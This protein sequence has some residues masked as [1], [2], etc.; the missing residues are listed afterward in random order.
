MS[1]SGSCLVVDS[2]CWV[3]G[4]WLLF[5]CLWR[6]CCLSCLFAFPVGLIGR[7]CSVI[8]TLFWASPIPLHSWTCSRFSADHSAAAILFF[9]RH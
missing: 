6:V 4:S 1:S 3:R 9:I 5:C 2:L 7:V 8:V